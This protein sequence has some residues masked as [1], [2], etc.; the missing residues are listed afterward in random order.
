M[1]AEDQERAGA[2]AY[3]VLGQLEEFGFYF[4][5]HENSLEDFEEG[6]QRQKQ[7]PA[8]KLPGP[9]GTQWPLGLGKGGWNGE[10]L[11]VADSILMMVLVAD[12][13]HVG[14]ER[15]RGLND[16]RLGAP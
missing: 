15:K 11:S 6:G 2:G 4:K 3:R 14:C 10:K 16:S 5:F 7:G 13:W 8:R 9:G 12:T 1:N